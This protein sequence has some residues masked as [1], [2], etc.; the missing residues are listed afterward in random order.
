MDSYGFSGAHAV[1]TTHSFAMKS[2]TTSHSKFE[3]SHQKHIRNHTQ[4]WKADSIET[5]HLN[6]SLKLCR[7]KKCHMPHYAT[8]TTQTIIWRI[9]RAIKSL[10]KGIPVMNPSGAGAQVGVG[11]AA[12]VGHAS[13]KLATW[14]LGCTELLAGWRGHWPLQVSKAVLSEDPVDG[15]TFFERPMILPL[16]EQHLLTVSA[17]AMVELEVQATCCSQTA[18]WVE[19]N[20]IRIT[21][22]SRQRKELNICVF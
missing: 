12:D 8:G 16:S 11:S 21:S 6:L 15:S 5:M 9:S 14:T 13:Y 1:C 10:G 20:G 18:S 22:L 19:L 17:P 7:N 4:T 2:C 3:E